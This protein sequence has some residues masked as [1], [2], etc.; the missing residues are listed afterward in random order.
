MIYVIGSGP[1][2]ISC[3]HALLAQGREVT[4]LDAG[5][6]LEKDKLN[7][8]TKLGN[9]ERSHWAPE[10]I[11]S[12]KGNMESG[13]GG[14]PL[15]LIYGS[16]FPYRHTEQLGPL[17]QTGSETSASMAKGGL[18]NVWGSALMPYHDRDMRDWPINADDLAPHY[19]AVLSFMPLARARSVEETLED[20]FPLYTDTPETFNASAQARALMTDVMLHRNK[21][22]GEGIQVG[23]AR[24]A[25]RGSDCIYC[26]LCMYGCPHSL[27]YSSSFS[28]AG[29]V[30]QPGFHYRPGV[31]VTKIKE[32]N[33]EVEIHGNELDTSPTQTK[34][35]GKPLVFNGERAFLACGPLNSTRIVMESLEAYDR[36]IVLKDSRYY[37]FPFLRYRSTP[38][39]QTED[40]HTLAQLYMEIF[41]PELVERTVHL[42][43][44][45]YNDLFTGALQSMFGPLYKVFNPA[46]RPLLERLFIFQGYIH[47]NFAPGMQLTLEKSEGNLPG[48]LR[49]IAEQDGKKSRK[50][51]SSVVKKINR[52]RGALKGVALRPMLKVSSPGRGFHS[53]GSLPMSVDP[54][55]F[56]SDIL[57]RPAGFNLLHVVDSSVLPSIPATTITFSVMANSHRIASEALQ[58]KSQ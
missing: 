56:Q 35:P 53:G 8:V 52:Q 49:I 55:E 7:L 26:G 41:D 3:V 50:L 2:G 37:L 11:N 47:S 48:T 29:L 45:S 54:G 18:S 30:G 58:T 24:L 32:L 19:R 25:L 44:Y 4:L 10:D 22:S 5:F 27:I 46:F 9:Q 14:I 28:L 33:G 51:I 1:A 17:A 6:T 34:E 20:E 38:K 12:L 13:A 43:L 39:V 21:L 36:T 40:L 31:L 16:D 23:S 15:K 57:G 42:Q